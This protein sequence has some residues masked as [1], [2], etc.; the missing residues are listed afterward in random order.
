VNTLKRA[1]KLMV[2]A[3]GAASFLASQAAGSSSAQK[4]T[5]RDSLGRAVEVPTR[6]ERILSLQPEITRI[7]VALGAGDRL[8]GLDYFLRRDDHV[9]KIIYPEQARLP[10]VSKPDDSVNKE[11]IVALS[12]DIIFASPSEFLVPD[13]IQRALGLP[14]VAL[15][16]L[17]S[18]D[19]LLEEIELVGRIT[20]LDKRAKE[21]ADYFREN[22][23]AVARALSSVPEEERPRVYLAFWSSLLRTP[24]FYEPVDRA[25]GENVAAGLLPSFTGSPGTVVTIEQ[26]IKWDPDIIL[27]HGN[28][29]PRERQVTVDEIMADKRL[30]SVKAV[31]NG[32][33]FYTFGYWYWWDP[34]EV[35]VETLYLANLFYPGKFGDIDIDAAG[36]AIFQKFYGSPDIFSALARALDFHDWIKRK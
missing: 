7:I 31:R 29:L 25:G 8:V 30:S 10:V 18:F 22:M 6:A 11:A 34:A 35:L 9:F 5:L 33:V 28:Y 24:V 36:N 16:S 21:L 2:L 17:G 13:S 23:A 32:R 12:P 1:L 15:S 4:L 27:V 20:G 19:R 3:V 26:V 14:V